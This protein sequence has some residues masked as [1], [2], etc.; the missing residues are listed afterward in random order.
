MAVKD[1]KAYA[2][3]VAF[4]LCLVCSVLVTGAAIALRPVQ[5]SAKL[6][7]KRKNI[8]RVVNMYEPGINLDEAFK[9]ITPKIVDLS[10][11]QLSDAVDPAKYDQY[12]AAKDPAQGGQV[13]PGDDDIA[14]IKY[15]PRYVT[16]YYIYNEDGSPKTVILPISGYGLWST[17]YGFLAVEADGNTVVGINFYQHAE[18]PGLGGEVDNQ[19]WKALWPGK[20]IYD[21]KG[22]VA[23]H[24]VKG[25]VNPD[26][27]EATHQVD[28]LAGASL[29]S[30]GVSNLV[31]YWLSDAGFKSFLEQLGQQHAAAASATPT[32]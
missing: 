25:G 19:K 27:P 18:T 11:G 12:A 29:T 4:V 10:T 15:M 1:T 21:D 13:I 16:V 31:H 7:D 22:Q 14:K 17:L 23:L 9:K 26:S 3:W 2:L 20:K 30:N 32:T 6:D 8:L 5:Q 24:L 28:A